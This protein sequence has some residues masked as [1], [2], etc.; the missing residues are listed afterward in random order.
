MLARL[1]EVTPRVTS[2]TYSLSLSLPLSLCV[3]LCPSVC[4][5][6]KLL[7][8]SPKGTLLSATSG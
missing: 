6:E 1:R 4:V 7:M 2:I 8:K 3:P 5:R